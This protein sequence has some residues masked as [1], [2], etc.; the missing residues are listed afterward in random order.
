MA[1]V[2][3]NPATVRAL[4]EIAIRCNDLPCMRD[5]YSDIVGLSLWHDFSQQG[6]IVFFR[7]GQGYG[8]H[9]TVLALFDTTAGR[10]R[11]F[12]TASVPPVTGGASALHH[13]ALT[14]DYAAQDDL[15]IFLDRHSIAHRTE[16][17]DWIGWR[18]VFITD[19]EGNVIEFVAACPASPGS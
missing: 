8:G 3:Q 14:V 10:D 16:V 18:G 5:F 19:P 13:L 1:Y 15:K 6:G 9:T 7:I 12:P 11:G 2:I 4:G 17:F